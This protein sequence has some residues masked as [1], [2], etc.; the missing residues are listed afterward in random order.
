M[1]WAE[2]RLDCHFRSVDR[3]LELSRFNANPTK[4][5]M[6]SFIRSLAFLPDGKSLL[7][8]SG[9]GKV[10]HWDLPTGKLRQTF[11]SHSTWGDAMALSTDGKTVAFGGPP[12]TLHFWNIETGNRSYCS[13]SPRLHQTPSTIQLSL[14]DSV[15]PWSR[16]AVTRKFVCGIR[17]PAR[18]DR[19]S[20]E[21]CLRRLCPAVM[22]MKA[23][24]FPSGR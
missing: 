7:A 15:R 6:W 8:G 11:E 5:G 9:E 19:T 2:R 14:R 17:R 23:W 16:P 10:R 3:S 22:A 1:A 24:H 4:F 13:G 18:P 20:S 12:P 21:A